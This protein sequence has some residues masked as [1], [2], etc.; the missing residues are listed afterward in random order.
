MSQLKCPSNRDLCLLFIFLFDFC[1]K[2]AF[3]LT[4]EQVVEFVF[5][6]LFSCF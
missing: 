6:K 1:A 4:D 3:D 5:R 2:R